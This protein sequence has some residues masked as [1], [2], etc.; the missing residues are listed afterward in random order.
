LA[1]AFSDAGG[2]KEQE[3]ASDEGDSAA[4]ILE[5]F[6]R[7]KKGSEEGRATE[8]SKRT[9]PERKQD[10]KSMKNGAGSQGQSAKESQERDE[11]S[12]GETLK[13]RDVFHRVTIPPSHDQVIQSKA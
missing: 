6:E 12:A 2:S 1:F 11:L 8:S 7:Q 5:R 9:I 10:S 3:T 13:K 4:G